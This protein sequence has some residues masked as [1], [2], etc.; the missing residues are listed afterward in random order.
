[1]P[2]LQ[3]V[4]DL[5]TICIDGGS[6]GPCGCNI[7]NSS[8]LPGVSIRYTGTTCT[9]TLAQ[10]AAG[11]EIP[12]QVE[13]VSATPNVAPASQDVGNCEMPDQS[14][15]ILFARL[16]GMSQQYCQCDVGLCSGPRLKPPIT[17]TAGTY[18]ESFS[19]DGKNWNG[20]SDTNQPEAAPFPVGSY[21]LDVSAVG[22][23]GNAS[24]TVNAT[25][26]IQLVP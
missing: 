6:G 4:A 3:S 10:A 18:P 22:S 20:P 15:L 25:L 14:G 9:F 16:A 26:G 21:T 12:Y 24:F 17:L 1:M 11:I 7:S 8:T 13:I 19:W 23:V 2:D 5:S